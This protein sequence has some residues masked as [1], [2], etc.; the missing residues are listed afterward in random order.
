MELSMSG[1]TGVRRKRGRRPGSSPYSA[2]DP[3][4]LNKVVERMAARPGLTKT[5]AIKEL[6]GVHKPADLHRL[7]EK[8]ARS[9]LDD[10]VRDRRRL[11]LLRQDAEL[12][13]A[14]A[15]RR[16]AALAANANS[17]VGSLENARAATSFEAVCSDLARI[18]DSMKFGLGRLPDF[19]ALE[20]ATSLGPAWQD[21]MRG[22]VEIS[23]FARSLDLVARVSRL[24]LS[25]L[26][27]RDD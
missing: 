10:Q 6:I 12:S 14:A 26:F 22:T 27:G 7:Q 8:F 17:E 20:K 3:A 16:D 18:S 24:P 21:L 13:L 1:E 2:S 23:S 25:G 15:G 19:A 4:L 9:R 11:E 5:A